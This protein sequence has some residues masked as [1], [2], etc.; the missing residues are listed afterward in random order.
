MAWEIAGAHKDVTKAET[1]L[2]P[3]DIA[4][5]AADGN[6][7]MFGRWREYMETMPGTRSC[8]VSA[9]L[10]AKLNI[11]PPGDDGEGGEQVLHDA[12][13]V[14][15]RVDA[16]KWRI[17]MRHGLAG[18]FLS[19]VEAFGQEGF[20][21]VVDDTERE[22]APLE[23]EYQRLRVERSEGRQAERREV[24]RA[25]RDTAFAKAYAIDRLRR[26]ADRSGSRDRIVRVIA[27]AAAVFPAARPL[28]PSE[29]YQAVA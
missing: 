14:V 4:I 18:T 16:G 15:G 7:A 24:D 25:I 3:W 13:E 21:A 23:A 26:L 12:D 29:L 6:A 1:S 19:R 20:D 28:E 27:E 2:T 8:V 22:V 5:A 10:S 11:P 9:A 17:W